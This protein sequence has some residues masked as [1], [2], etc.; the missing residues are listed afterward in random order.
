MKKRQKN[1]TRAAALQIVLSLG[2]LSICVIILA[3][4]ASRTAAKDPQKSRGLEEEQQQREERARQF[5]QEHSDASGTVRPD[6]WRKGI[7]DVQKMRIGAGINLAP[8]GASFGGVVGV[9]WTQNGPAP[10]RIDHEQNFQG[11][12]PDSGEVVDI[13]IDPRNATDNVIYI[14]TN[15]GGIWKSTDGGTSWKPKTDY[16]LSLS[17]G[18]VEL[19][20]A[21]PSIVYAG[22]GNL[23]DGSGLF[24]KGVGIYRSIDA[25]ETWTTVGAAALNGSG[26][27]RIVLPST[28]VLLV[29]TGS[30]GTTRMAG[31]LFRSIDG[32]ANFGNNP[33]NFNNNQPIINGFISDLALDTTTPTTV[34]AAVR[35]SGIFR[36]TDSGATFPTNLFNNPGAPG[37]GTFS[38]TSFSQSTSPNNQTIYAN[39]QQTANTR[40]A[41][42]YRSTDA[43][44]NWTL[45]AGPA[46]NHSDQNG[47]PPGCQCGYDQTI[48]V[49]P[50]DANRVYIGF[51]ELYV[52]IDGGV[53]FGTPAVSR[54]KIH[55]DHHAITFSPPG[56][57]TPGDLT[58]RVFVG[59]DGGI[60]YSD[61]GGGT[62]SNI[63]EGIATNILFSMDIGR[64]SAANNGFT[65][66]GTQDT[67]TIERRAA[68]FAGKDWHLGIDGD[69]GQIAVDPFNPMRAYGTDNGSYSVTNDGGDN[70]AFDPGGTGITG[71]GVGFL[72]V[73]P[74]NGMVVY[75]TKGA[76]LYQSVD[77]GAT[78]TLIK[79]FPANI[80]ALA[81]VRIDSNTFWVALSNQTVQHSANVLSGTT[82]TWTSNNVTGAPALT[83]RGIAIDPTNTDQVVVVYSGFSGINPPNRT[84]HVFRTLDNG[85]FWT[86]ISGTDGG[87]P[88]SNLPDL[89]LHSVVIDPDTSPH[90]Y[91][92]AS[93]AGVM[94]SAD[95]GP[96][97]QVLGV[98]LPT[99]YCSS[100]QI[101]TTATP[102]LLR[103]GT[104]GR[105]TFELTAAT[106]P[107]LAVNANLAFGPICIG[108]SDTRLLQL[109]NV[110][111]ADLHIASIVRVSGSNA[112]QITGPAT[113]VTIQP[114]E[115]LDF[116]VTYTPTEIGNQTATFQINSDDPFQPAFQV[117]ATG[118]TSPPG[119]IRVTG[120]T[121]FGDVCPGTL[122]E[123]TV[124]VCNV[125]ACDLHVTGASLSCPDFTLVNNP[126]PATVSH[127][128]CLNL[129]I[130]F[131]P[132]S[133]GPKSCTLTIT[134]DDPN[135][136]V[137]NLTVTGNTPAASIDVPLDATF[138]PTVIQSI[139]PCHSANPFPISN[140]GSCNLT[141][142]NITIS[143]TNAGDYSLSGLPSFPIILEPG[144]IVGEGDLSVVFS[145]T[146]VARERRATID[147]TY[148]SNPITH[149]T[150]TVTRMLCGE[151]VKTGAR[152]LVEAAGVPL[153]S[154]KKIQLQ[155]LTVNKDSDVVHNAPLQTVTPTLPCI[156]FQ[157]HRE[158]GTVS[159]P[160][161]LLT[162]SYQVTVQATIN[163]H[164]LTQTAA[165]ELGTCDFNPNVVV[166]FP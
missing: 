143:G 66:G 41:D 152:V 161:Q 106:G 146:V 107:L 77:I 14:A 37:A 4:A 29:A 129:V 28:G 104:Y 109:F 5:E 61:D 36:S 47:S 74:N 115:E 89:P 30:D 88:T 155:R 164:N 12:G 162:G 71:G 116:T 63:N 94:R 133:P 22:T 118:S 13:A 149:S 91:M 119:E 9:Q 148:E 82:A 46:A 127:D 132:T 67:G 80:T 52:S 86:D 128:S 145:P 131:T 120:S 140:T 87:N 11:A 123:R 53:T 165:F 72:A 135:N 85:T 49:D 31:A 76:Q 114:G 105:S 44:G 90:T 121:T 64:N 10:L 100:L 81:T 98:G 54:D 157:F 32:G 21:N 7:E 78:F 55:W 84:K 19:D 23:F 59:E 79:T 45:V 163:G 60:A 124:S 20:P 158:Y 147:V 151:G 75:A 2:L 40:R 141:I 73:D 110:G 112:F 160:I 125:G 134:S 156:P 142:T 57:R 33:P 97:W 51:Q 166:N 102:S 58:T 108:S 27:N 139:G 38:F 24:T 101:D 111:S 6:L 113:P 95:G 56:H 144:H 62:F 122:A 35:G 159:N 1:S 154:V 70:W 150:T 18:A 34:Y 65:Y 117:S 153:P 42:I 39:V 138:S 26:I 43:G 16:M 99:V 92:V 96:T 137:I 69:G 50:V 136:P 83:V 48:G 93:D 17:M 68:D 15:D 8:K 103:V 130:R 25:G 3:I 126:F